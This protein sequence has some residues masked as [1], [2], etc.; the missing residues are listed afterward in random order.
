MKLRI[1]G[2]S[3]RLRLTRPEV[4]QLLA[5]GEVSEA[6]HFAGDSVL[7]YALHTDIHANA[8]RASFDAALLAITVPESLARHW[9]RSNEV[10]IQATVPTAAGGLMILVEKDF[11]CLTE[12]PNEDDT[13]AFERHRLRIED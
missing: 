6:T 11:P 1:K 9:S 2:D 13:H 5:E 12:R 3:I 10:G 4:A 8:V 7:R